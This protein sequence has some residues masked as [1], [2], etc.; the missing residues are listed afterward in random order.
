LGN[1]HYTYPVVRI[2]EIHLWKREKIYAYP[3]PDYYWWN[4]G[5]YGPYGPWWGPFGPY[6]W[7]YGPGDWD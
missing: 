7:P 6:S 1:I 3:P 5:W 2:K 4:W